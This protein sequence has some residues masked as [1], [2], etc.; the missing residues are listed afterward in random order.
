MDSAMRGFQLSSCTVSSK[1]PLCYRGK[2]GVIKSELLSAPLRQGGALHEDLLT[3]VSCI[4]GRAKRVRPAMPRS[5][6]ISARRVQTHM[7]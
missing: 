2:W 7:R 5:N 4:G 1:P 6:V 3:V